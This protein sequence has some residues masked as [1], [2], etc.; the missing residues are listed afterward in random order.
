MLATVLI[1]L[2]LAL[3]AWADD[4]NH[5]VASVIIIMVIFEIESFST[6]SMRSLY[7]G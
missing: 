1:A 4:A 6:H 3:G 5:Q 7:C 2:V